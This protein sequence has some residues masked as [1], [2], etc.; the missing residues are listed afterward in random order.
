MT[1]GH[2]S[3]SSTPWIAPPSLADRPALDVIFIE[4]F[5]GHTVIGIHETELHRAQPLVI[6]V[7]AGLARAR[8]CDTDRI[9]D[10]IDYGAVCERLRRLLAEH[11]LQLLEAFAEAI[12][13]IVIREFGAI[14]V[15]VKVAKPRKFD[16]VNAVGVQIERRAPPDETLSSHSGAVLRLIGSGMVPE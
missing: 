10:T 7:H 12:A 3:P 2:H 15:R 1:S 14:W 8:A 6:D 11:E 16:D 5:V 9:A 13:D 4:G